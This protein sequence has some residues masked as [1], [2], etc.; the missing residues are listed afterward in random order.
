MDNGK[1]GSFISLIGGAANSLETTYT[2]EVNIN[3]GGLYRFRYRSKNINGWSDWSPITNVRAATIPVRPPAPTFLTA[4]ASSITLGLSQSLNSR[5]S[6]I[7]HYELFRNT[8]GTSN[9][10][11]IVSTYDGQSNSH[12]LTTLLDFIAAGSIYK[13][14]Y[15]AINSYGPSDFSDEVDGG[16]SSFPAQPAIPIK[17]ESESSE[18]FI[19]LAWA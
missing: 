9:S 17:I 8:G 18:N 10:Y 5:G 12:I 14:K 6:D 19:T 13:F 11:I 4:T 3:K 1:G 16:I 7:T 2:T 15:R